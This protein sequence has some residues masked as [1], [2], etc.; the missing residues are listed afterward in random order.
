[1]EKLETYC[2]YE[3]NL[4]YG[5]IGVELRMHCV[6]GIEISILPLSLTFTFFQWRGNLVI[7][8]IYIYLRPSRHT[9]NFAPLPCAILVQALLPYTPSHC[10]PKSLQALHF[11]EVLP[12]I[13][14]FGN[15]FSRENCRLE[16]SAT[17]FS[18]NF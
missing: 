4:V 16:V 17:F 10:A 15:Y 13:P 14:F 3:W 5:K 2:V 8:I 11:S 1:M 6:T 9:L 12:W 7:W 18:P